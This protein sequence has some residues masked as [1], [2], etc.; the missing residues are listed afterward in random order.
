M[1]Y[2]P[3]SSSGATITTQE[4]GV[5]LSTTV[6]TLNFTGAGATASGAGATTTIDIPGGLTQPQVMARQSVGF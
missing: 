5:N 1:P 4:E 3:P 6:N 2:Y